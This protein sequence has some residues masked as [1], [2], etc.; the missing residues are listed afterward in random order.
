MFRKEKFIENI[1]EFFKKYNRVVSESKVNEISTD[2]YLGLIMALNTIFGSRRI[3]SAGAAFELIQREPDRIDDH[4]YIVREVAK[5]F[6]S[7]LEAF[8]VEEEPIGEE[9]LH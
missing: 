1:Q 3:F 8:L 9:L 4:S 6:K 7:E 5:I 2:E